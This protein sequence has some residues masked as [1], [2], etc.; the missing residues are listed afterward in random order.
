MQQPL[1]HF[2]PK[3]HPPSRSDVQTFKNFIDITQKLLVLTGAGISTESGIPDYRSEGVGLYARSN[4]K[5][6]QYKQFLDS[7]EVRRRYWAR[8]YVGWERFSKAQPNFAHDWLKEWEV[9]R[10]RVGAVVTQNVDGLHG[11]AGSA[12]V[13]ELHGTAYKVICL[14]CNESYSRHSVQR[15]IQE[16]NPGMHEAT[17]MIRPD[18]D[19]EI[20]QEKIA[21]FKPP[22]CPRC[23]GVLKPD[24]VFFGD[25][26]PKSR[27]SRVEAAVCE[28]DGVLVLGSS[29]SVYSAY[30]I[31]LQAVD[32][33]KKVAIV[34][35]GSTRADHC[36]HFRISAR[37]GDILRQLQTVL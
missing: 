13:I 8:N 2:V 19:V 24:I 23:S 1:L 10:G 12:N 30:R 21:Q 36:A 16:L 28:S 25:N 34:N 18:G 33:K 7:E 26:I 6:V 9:D 32:L 20:S 37:C 15:T 14:S 29:L 31:I 22:E 11:K 4:H 5:P 27:V 17:T 3:H 35:I